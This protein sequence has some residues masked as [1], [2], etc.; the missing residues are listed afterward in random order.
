MLMLNKRGQAI[1][2]YAVLLA[3][4]VAAVLIMQMFVKRGFQGNLMDASQKMGDSFSAGET[5]I[6]KIS[7]LDETG[8]S[9]TEE[10]GTDTKMDPFIQS[11]TMPDLKHTL[12]NQAYSYNERTGGEQSS[13][14]KTDTG[15][16][17][18]EKTRISEYQDTKATNFPDPWAGNPSNN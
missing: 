17:R 1:I 13:D 16:A 18:A 4:I 9:I 15:S 11:S 2:E 5:S 10:T 12:D 8:Q 6:Q 7:K 3:V 14:T